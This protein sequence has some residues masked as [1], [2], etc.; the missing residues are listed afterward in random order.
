MEFQVRSKIT[1]KLMGIDN[2]SIDTMEK[3]QAFVDDINAVDLE[4]NPVY[5]EEDKKQYY[6]EVVSDNP[7]SSRAAIASRGIPFVGEH[8]DEIAGAFNPEYTDSIRTQRKAMEETRPKESL[9]WEIGTGIVTTAPFVGAKVLQSAKG[10]A[11]AIA[12]RTGQGAA[13]GGAEG[14]VSGYGVG[15]GEYFTPET[16]ERT[17][18]EGTDLFLDD[19][20]TTLNAERL[21][22]ARSRSMI[23]AGFGATFGFGG[24]VI[25]NFKRQT[26]TRDINKLAEGLGISPEAANIVSN[27]VDAG[28]TDKDVD[29][30]LRMMGEDARVAMM[31]PEYANLLD[32]AK[33][34]PMS[35]AGDTVARGVQKLGREGTNRFEKNLD[36]ILGPAG[37]GP[38]DILRTAR[39]RTA[40]PREDAY[41]KTHYVNFDVDNPSRNRLRTVDYN[42]R[43]G[44][45]INQVLSRIPDRFK[46]DAIQYANEMAQVDGIKNFG[47]ITDTPNLMQLDYIKRGLQKIVR[48]NTDPLSGV[49]SDDGILVTGLQ[50]N[51]NDILKRY[52]PEYRRAS[53][54]GLDAIQEDTAIKFINKFNT[55]PLEDFKGLMGSV[56]K[57]AKDQL[58]DSMKR[59]FRTHIQEIQDKVRSTLASPSAS[60]EEIKQAMT[61]MTQLSSSGAKKKMATFMTGTDLS[62]VQRQ[63]RRIQ[64]I[65]KIQVAVRTGSQTAGRQEGM[66]AIKELI[67]D[68]VFAEISDGRLPAVLS[69]TWKALFG[70]DVRLNQE[71]VG[72]I[73]D[74]VAGVLIDTTGFQA[75]QA[76]DLIRKYKSGSSL[77][78][79]EARDFG[80]YLFAGVWSLGS[81]IGDTLQAE[82]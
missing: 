28:A 10:G 65:A 31:G 42:S 61:V 17:E 26:A 6:E 32:I 38:K 71:Q 2:P 30:I 15:E 36:R 14:A 58:T 20:G 33:L 77:S 70:Q 62:R 53:Q 21:Q 81:S 47:S 22:N 45:V 34:V 75:R 79:Q 4:G 8:I 43:N 48:E 46:N 40:K 18:R 9:A 25:E 27:V 16:G 67:G 80:R 24:G 49:V 5:T 41:N 55:T 73:L 82:E 19:E 76:K 57:E 74:E 3:A 51:L 1:D 44:R 72:K 69:R 39:Q 29:R 64:E 50:R 37:E 52:S 68:N 12:S 13:M 78:I 11:G 35:G 56:E 54:L 7:V 59:M 66:E 60:A 63:F 23:G